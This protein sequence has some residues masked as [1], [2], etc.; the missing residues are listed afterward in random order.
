MGRPSTIAEPWKTLA[1]K[2]G[3]VGHLALELQSARRTVNQWANGDRVPS[4][5]T[6]AVIV[7]AFIKHGVEPPTF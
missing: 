6:Q 4:R 3:G 7:A 1:D 2:L 5:L